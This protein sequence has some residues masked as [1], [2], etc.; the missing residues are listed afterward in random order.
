MIGA[1]HHRFTMNSPQGWGIQL[2]QNVDVIQG[3]YL[4]DLMAQPRALEATWKGLRMA[5]SLEKIAGACSRDRFQ[6]V[7]LTGMGASYFGLHPLCI[8][9]ATHGW[10]PMMLETSELIY[11]YRHLLTPATLVVAVSQSGASAETVRLLE[12]NANRATIIGVTNSAESPLARGAQFAVLTAAGEEYSVSCKTYVAA[13]MAHSMLSAV[14]CGADAAARLN[15]LQSA[16]SLAEGYLS[17]WRTHVGEWAE[18]LRNVRD[19]FLVGRGRSLAAAR[20]GALTTKESTHVHAEGMSSAA[21]RHGPFEMLQAGIF[22]GVFGGDGETRSLNDGL[23]KDAA[24]TPAT[25]AMIA[26]DAAQPA[27][28][29]PEATRAAAP[30]VEILP[31][32]MMTLALAAL[33]GRE[34]GKFERA[35]KITVVE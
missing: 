3:R 6:R 17:G 24:A 16:P 19:I 27:C 2:P 15:E 1:G 30:I 10:T 34:A 32:Q 22:V 23:V 7:V 5:T 33:A 21:F 11:Y 25:C 20:T 13:Q 35:T 31:V 26:T 8:D 14:L 9:L 4:T 18:L 29:L 12:L 28:R